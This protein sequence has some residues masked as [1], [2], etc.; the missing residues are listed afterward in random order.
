MLLLVRIFFLTICFALIGCNSVTQRTNVSVGYYNVKGS[1]F[2]ELDREIALH[3]PEVKGVGNAIAAA[4]IK[5]I[6]RIDYILRDEGCVV[7]HVRIRVDAKVTLPRLAQKSRVS[8]K[9]RGAF[10]NMQNY[11]KLHESVHVSI[12]DQFAEKAERAIRQIKPTPTCK[13]LK[14]KI[15]AVYSKI[16][17]QHQ[18]AQQQ[19]DRDEQKRFADA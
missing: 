17:K 10:S 9:V 19:F 13:A 11:A 18:R 16:L 15:T 7:T 3:G 14:A 12:A 8:K 1:T 5:M 6:P 2:E 4:S